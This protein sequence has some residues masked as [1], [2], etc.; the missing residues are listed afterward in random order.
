MAMQSRFRLG[1]TITPNAFE[2]LGH[3]GKL[4][5]KREQCDAACGVEC[6]P[7]STQLHELIVDSGVLLGKGI[8]ACVA[9]SA[10]IIRYVRLKRAS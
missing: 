1:R 8:S 5:S 2:R 3:S 7:E 9:S 10:I 6:L 4:S